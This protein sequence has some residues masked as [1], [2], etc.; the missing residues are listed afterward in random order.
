M[1]RWFRT[2]LKDLAGDVLLGATARARGQMRP[3]VVEQLLARHGAG[4]ADHG[5][6]IWALLML[7]LWQ[8]RF[9]DV[10]SSPA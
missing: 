8:Q 1:A 9:V 2:D 3:E 10:G 4:E 7:E 6:R 5:E